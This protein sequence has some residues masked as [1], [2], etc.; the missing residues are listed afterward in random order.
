MVPEPPIRESVSCLHLRV[1]DR[2]YGFMRHLRYMI[3]SNTSDAPPLFGVAGSPV[4][5]RLFTRESAS[6]RTVGA[7]L[8]V[9]IGRPFMIE[10]QRPIELNRTRQLCH[11]CAVVFAFFSEA[12]I[13]QKHSS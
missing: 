11:R 3:V 4:L 2:T 10:S 8:D 7:P 6:F 9:R 13:R 5:H 1:Y 12:F